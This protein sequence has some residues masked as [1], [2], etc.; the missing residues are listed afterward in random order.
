[1]VAHHTASFSGGDPLNRRQLESK[2]LRKAGLKVTGPRLKILEILEGSPTRHM[3]RRRHLQAPDRVQRGHRSRDGVSRAHA[4]PGRRPGVAASFRRRHGRVR[5][6][7]GNASRPYRV[8]GLRPRRRVHR[9]IDRRAPGSDRATAGLRAARSRH[10]ALRPLPQAAAAALAHRST[11]E[12]FSRRAA[13]A[14]R[15]PLRASD[16]G[17]PPSAAFRARVRAPCR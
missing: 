1:M 6:Q 7:P 9:R 17:C 11:A 13:Q 4:V 12:T 5:A 3:S 10:D 15:L 16:P 14:L 2:D 8:S